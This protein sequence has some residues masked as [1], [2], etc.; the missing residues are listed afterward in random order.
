MPE[1][2]NSLAKSLLAKLREK[3]LVKR[4]T[5]D[6]TEPSGLPKVRDNEDTTDPDEPIK[7]PTDP[8]FYGSEI[9]SGTGSGGAMGE[10][11]EGLQ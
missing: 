6:K 4:P 5:Q 2:V 9:V 11:H 8:G 7:G 3:S 1:D 10:E